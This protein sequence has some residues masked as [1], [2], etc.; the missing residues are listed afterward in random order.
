MT[1]KWLTIMKWLFNQGD[2]SGATGEIWVRSVE[3]D[4][5]KYF[6]NVNSLLLTTVLWLN[7]MLLLGEHGNTLWYF[8]NIL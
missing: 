7:K 5:I 6:N 8:C 3:G 4:R 2:I 1:T